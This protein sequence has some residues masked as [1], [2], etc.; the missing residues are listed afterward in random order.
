ML[1]LCPE[2]SPFTRY[3]NTVGRS[4]KGPR[5]V[6]LRQIT[7]YATVTSPIGTMERD[8]ES[9]DAVGEDAT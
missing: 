3:E 7:T 5:L 9:F 6:D 4:V 8:N 1:P 2:V